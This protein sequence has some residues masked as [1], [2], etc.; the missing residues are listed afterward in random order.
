MSAKIPIIIGSNNI[1]EINLSLDQLYQ[2]P[3]KIKEQ[4]WV[5]RKLYV[6][7]NVE[8]QIF[9]CFIDYF[10]QSKKNS[11]EELSNV[12]TFQY[13]L[14]IKELGINNDLLSDH[15]YTNLLQISILNSIKN[16]FQDKSD[17]EQYIADNLILYIDN[18][19]KEMN[20]I[21]I[22]S[23][24]NII[25][26]SNYLES[27]QDKIYLF[28][29]SLEDKNCFILLQHL[30]C[31]KLSIEYTIDCISNQDKHL[32][33]LPKNHS[34]FIKNIFKENKSLKQDNERLNEQ[35]QSEIFTT[36][37]NHYQF[38]I[39]DKKGILD[40]SASISDDKFDKG[41]IVS[42]SS[43]DMY[44]IICPKEDLYDGVYT[45][46]NSYILNCKNT[47]IIIELKNPELVSSIKFFESK[48]SNYLKKIS[49][50]INDDENDVDVSF[51]DT[52]EFQ[53][54]D[55]TKR[56]ITR[57]INPT[58]LSKITINIKS[59]PEQTSMC[60]PIFGGLELFSGKYP[61]GIFK[62]LVEKDRNHDPHRCGVYIE[63]THFCANDIYHEQKKFPEGKYISTYSIENSW[64]KIEL[65][66]GIALINGFRLQKLDEGYLLLAHYKIIATD[67]PNKNESEWP[68][69]YE[70]ENADKR[71]MV[72]EHLDKYYPVKIVKIIITGH[73]MYKDED[74]GFQ[75]HFRYFDIFGLFIPY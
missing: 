20:K 3:V 55:T 34:H 42:L 13:Y 11:D 62:N 75:L 67:D 14:L 41:F 44:S 7:S 47:S 31:L 25:S 69:I 33:I 6:H 10:L 65:T 38:N 72:E 30:D 73:N 17:A 5:D 49:Y 74:R 23:L 53:S 54:K 71:R 52:N 51:E 59:T 4:I 12:D 21:P 43:S 66:K 35:L 36:R 40:F 22:T 68:I 37:K 56:I 60:F 57:S 45:M 1:I 16:N 58:I 9:Q 48:K 63:S 8:P 50:K 46:L 2:F 32:N 19:P 39:Q 70:T 64:V 28:I 15:K 18:F 29:K 26:K 27:N 61:E 24:Y